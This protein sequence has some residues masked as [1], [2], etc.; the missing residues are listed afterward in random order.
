MSGEEPKGKRKRRKR[1][2]IAKEISENYVES[3]FNVDNIQNNMVLPVCSNALVDVASSQRSQPLCKDV[4]RHPSELVNSSAP[5]ENTAEEKPVN[6]SVDFQVAFHLEDFEPVGRDEYS[7]ESTTDNTFIIEQGQN[8]HSV[9]DKNGEDADWLCEYLTKIQDT[10]NEELVHIEQEIDTDDVTKEGPFEGPS[11]EHFNIQKES[12]DDNLDFKPLY[13]GATITVGLSALLIMTFALRHMLSGE[14]LS[15]ML[16]LISAHCLS[17]NLCTK[18]MFEL[19]KH[20]HN[21]KAPMRFHRYC[22]YCFLQVENN[23]TVCPNSF[24]ARDLTCSGNT[25]FFI[26]IPIASQIQ[27][28]FARPGFLNLLKHRFVRVKKHEHNIE[29]IYD[30]ELYKRHTGINGILSDKSNISLTWNTDGIPVFKSSKFALWPLYFVINELPYKERISKDNMIFAG[31]WFGSSKPSMLTFLQP[32]HSSLS[33]LENEGLLIK[34]SDE[35]YFTTRVILLAGTCDLPAKCLV[36][37]TV[38]YNGFNGCFKCKQAGQTVKTGK[39]GGHVHAFP[40]DFD[41]PKGPKRT[42]AE[43]LDESQQAAA[44]GKPVNGIKG[45][46]WFGGLK[47]HDIIDGTGIDYMH[48]VLLGVCK[49][50]LGL[51]FDSGGTTDYKITSRISEV[52]A[53]LASIK[54]PNNISRVPRSIENHRKYFKASELRSFLLFYGP[55]VLYNILPKPYYEHFLL[56]S[57]AIFILLLDSISERQL[58]YV[59]R[60]LLH[61]CI[62]FEGYYGLRFQ[63]ANFHLLVHLADDVRSL[64]PLW[65]HSCFHFED[66]NGFLL[67]T[68]HGTQNIQFQIIS[69]V[70]IAKKLPELRRTFVPEDG[71]V[72][73]FY[74]KMTSSY[75]FSNG[76]ELSEGYF[77]LGASSERRLSGLQLQALA[78]F[79]GSAPPS[80]VV[81][82]FKRLKC[83][84]EILHSRSYERVRSRNSFTVSVTRQKDREYGHIEFFFQVKPICFCLSVATCNCTVRNLVVL[85][86]LRECVPI[87]LI[88][89]SSSHVKVVGAAQAE[90][91][92]VLDIEQ[93]ERKCVFM[94]FEDMPNIAF[95]ADFPNS[96]ETD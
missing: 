79:L 88:D 56:L 55:A 73:D 44:Q 37:N 69:A 92:I 66:K 35:N 2:E 64:G 59:E 46:S 14:A 33:T 40:F 13:S 96:V 70:S 42:H 65:T 18:S 52:D 11:A 78:D 48:C 29:D 72:T 7:I 95:V 60:S 54:P 50:L 32:F 45:P 16:T 4:P 5:S 6:R 28:F 62:L 84:S 83:G 77:A 76:I 17:P 8:S 90:D 12:E 9:D 39:K 15:D 86:R 91:V 22:S 24:C 36:C 26:E 19:K 20:F 93:I 58:E 3:S 57:E 27:E 75:R 71:P 34:S 31:L 51:W 47:H 1:A 85:T 87:K 30:G 25:A 67:K 61:F 68:F 74:Q 94:C 21:L 89:S 49:R 41:N 10:L 38:Q 43:T 81:K 82:S 23:L 80:P 53:R 63:T